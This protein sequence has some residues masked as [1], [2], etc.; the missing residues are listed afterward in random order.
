[1]NNDTFY[2]AFVDEFEKVAV[3]QKWVRK[4]LKDKG[5]GKLE[6]YPR[7]KY[8]KGRITRRGKADLEEMMN[9]R[10]KRGKPLVG[11]GKTG[12]QEWGARGERLGERIAKQEVGVGGHYDLTGKKTVIGGRGSKGPIPTGGKPRETYHHEAWHRKSPVLSTSETA[13]HTYGAIKAR[14]PGKIAKIK[15][16]LKSAKHGAKRDLSELSETFIA[17]VG[18]ALFGA[19]EKKSK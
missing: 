6:M 3:S 10:K 8:F 4:K 15:H 16:V 5:P 2:N 13:A 12:E 7:T 14:V 11:K 19:K 9:R 18:R 1:M 17:P